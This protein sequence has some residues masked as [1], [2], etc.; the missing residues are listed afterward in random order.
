M[1]KKMDFATKAKLI[2]SGEI[3]IFAV[4]FLVLATL[5]FLNVI[6]Y[7]G[8]RVRIFN[9]VT[10]FGGTWIVVD[11]IWALFDKKRQKRIAL[12]DK[13]IHAPAG[14][15]LIVFDLYCLITKPTDPELYRFGIAG[16]LAYL[17][18]CYVFEALYH[19]K[20]PVPGIIDAVE[21]EKIQ[22]EQ[23][24]EE[25]KNEESSKEESEEINNEQKD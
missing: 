9:W 18:L 6:Q 1:K 7:N 24:L 25:E 5:R 4:L 11:L 14:V 16:V 15:Y 13:I 20:Y 22:S 2:Y 12:I 10:I 23:A 21:Q 8:T 19:F 3:L 17:G